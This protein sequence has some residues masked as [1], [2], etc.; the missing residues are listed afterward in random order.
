M[1]PSLPTDANLA[2]L[3]ETALVA[4]L[5]GGDGLALSKGKRFDPGDLEH[6][7]PLSTRADLTFLLDDEG[8]PTCAKLMAINSKAKGV[9]ARRKLPR[10]LPMSGKFLSP[11]AMLWMLVKVWDPVPAHLEKTTP[12]FRD[13]SGRPFTADYVR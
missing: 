6:S 3:F 8:K 9:E 13:S 12:L 5:R 11:G 2:T 1:D 7:F 10:Y 4:V